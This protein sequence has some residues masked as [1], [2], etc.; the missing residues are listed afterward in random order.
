MRIQQ[1]LDQRAADKKLRELEKQQED[2]KAVLEEEQLNGSK[3][4]ANAEDYD[5]K[6][7]IIRAAETDEEK[8]RRLDE[9]KKKFYEEF[10]PDFDIDEVPP[11]E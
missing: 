2:A 1:R 10:K 7:F 5:C 6:S 8:K 9:K 3:K 11:L 4:L